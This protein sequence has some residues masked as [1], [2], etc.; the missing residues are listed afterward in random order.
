MKNQSSLLLDT[1]TVIPVTDVEL[2]VKWYEDIL[3]L[4]PV[5]IK[6]GMEPTNYA[7]CT[8]DK[9]HVHFIL[10]ENPDTRTWT[11]SG[12]AYLYIKSDNV[13]QEFNYIKM[14]NLPFIKHLSKTSWGLVGF[15]FQDPFGNTIRIEEI[16]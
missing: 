9:I 15:V 3:K 7:V 13:E 12:T 6:R 16:N 8:R 2:A 11:N 5:F 14:K 10:D 1:I 4:T